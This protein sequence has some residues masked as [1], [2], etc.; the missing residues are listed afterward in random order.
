[1]P[2][3][4]ENQLL[5]LERKVTFLESNGGD[6]DVD[7]DALNTELHG[8]RQRLEITL[9]DVHISLRNTCRNQGGQANEQGQQHKNENKENNLGD[10]GEAI[11]QAKKAVLRVCLDLL[12]P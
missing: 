2:A 5:N 6:R 12:T 10:A 9:R 8:V 7:I 11:P 1:M 4:I 3:S